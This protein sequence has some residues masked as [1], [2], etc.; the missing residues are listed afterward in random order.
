M[1]PD[2]LVLDEPTTS[3]DPPGQRELVELLRSLPQAKIV[4]T[5][6]IG[7]ARAIG[8]RAA[9]FDKGRVAAEGS[10]EEV[11]RRFDWE[12]YTSGV[13]RRG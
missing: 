12:P 13:V 9:F 4:T 11:V 7:F 10:V 8:D 2:L 6:D 1:E 3:L 5:H